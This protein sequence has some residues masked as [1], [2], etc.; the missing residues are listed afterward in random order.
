[1]QDV[2]PFTLTETTLEALLMKMY[3][4]PKDQTKTVRTHTHIHTRT[5]FPFSGNFALPSCHCVISASTGSEA[6]TR[7]YTPTERC[8]GKK[9]ARGHPCRNSSSLHS[10]RPFSGHYLPKTRS[11]DHSSMRLEAS[12][13]LD[14]LKSSALGPL[15]GTQ[16]CSSAGI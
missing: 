13:S 4:F 12:S 14:R 2:H 1:M 7:I 16:H 3:C 5:N 8:L 10:P 9:G 15:S 11:S 6:E